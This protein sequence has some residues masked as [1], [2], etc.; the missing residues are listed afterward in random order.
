MANVFG[1]LFD[2][3]GIGSLVG[4][5]DNQSE[6]SR[7]QEAR[8]LLDGVK[9]LLEPGGDRVQAFVPVAFGELLEAGN[10]KI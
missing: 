2:A 3:A 9:T 8:D 4:S 5:L 6:V 7:Q 10:G 1:H